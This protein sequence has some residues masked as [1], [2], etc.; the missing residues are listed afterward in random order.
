MPERGQK[1]TYKGKEYT[2]IYPSLNFVFV[3]DENG[4]EYKLSHDKIKPNEKKQ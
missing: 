3:V 2:V 4:K 1:I